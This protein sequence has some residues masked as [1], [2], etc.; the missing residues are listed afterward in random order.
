MKNFLKSIFWETDFKKIDL[1]KNSD[2]V[3]EKILEL[4]DIEQVKWLQEKYS[5][6]EIKNV[7]VNSRN[8]SRR[9][10]NFWA[11]YFKIP[12]NKIKCLIRE[13]QKTQKVLWPY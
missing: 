3:I 10:A 7:L 13:L 1:D 12:K 2:Q 4:G 6:K 8:L 11:D 9:T 5:Q